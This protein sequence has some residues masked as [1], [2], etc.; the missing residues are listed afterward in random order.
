MRSKITA[1]G[2]SSD[3]QRDPANCRRGTTAPFSR[4]DHSRPEML[5][6]RALAGRKL[7]LT[8]CAP[9]IA[10]ATQ[11]KLLAHAVNQQ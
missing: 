8:R 6:C 7:T 5:V 4:T 2:P 9:L 3:T 1:V 10:W 11:V